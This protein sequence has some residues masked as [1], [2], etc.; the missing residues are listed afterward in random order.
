MGDDLPPAVW[1]AIANSYGVVSTADAPAPSLA[2]VLRAMGFDWDHRQLTRL[3]DAAALPIPTAEPSGRT[4]PA[5][6]T[7]RARPPASGSK[8]PAAA[9]EQLTNPPDYA[10]MSSEQLIPLLAQYGLKAGSHVY[11]VRA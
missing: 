10:S 6:T 5:P 3:P 1:R 9:V 4:A 8:A 11:M 7:G 2:V